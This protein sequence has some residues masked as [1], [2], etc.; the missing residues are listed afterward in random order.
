MASVADRVVEHILKNDA[1]CDDCLADHAGLSRRQQVQRVTSV[2]ELSPD[3]LRI[4]D[5]CHFC[6]QHKLVIRRP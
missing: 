2:L 1:T 6:G 5:E 3:Y 4:K